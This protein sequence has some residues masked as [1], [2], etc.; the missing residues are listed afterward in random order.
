MSVVVVGVDRSTTSTLAFREAMREAAWRDA[1]VVVAYA[2]QR[3][4][5][6]A[7]GFGATA[8]MESFDVKGAGETAISEYLAEIE[9]TFDDGFPVPVTAEV[10]VGHAGHQLL[11]LA[12]RRD[13]DLVVLGSRGLGGVKGL[14]LG[15][16]TT[17]AV[18]HIRRPL[19]VVPALQGDHDDTTTKGN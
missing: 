1:S 14:L 3:P 4:V 10:L 5:Y 7:S 8:V 2:V 12:R 17:Y 13:A 6:A 19:L 18:H 11:E 15:S 16:V 9:A